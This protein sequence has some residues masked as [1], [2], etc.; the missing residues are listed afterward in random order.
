M[1]KERREWRKIGRIMVG[2][3]I[4]IM[5]IEMKGK[6]KEKLRRREIIK[7]IVDYMQSDKV[8]EYIIEE[9]MKW[10]LN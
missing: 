6:E 3:G 4:I 7:V 10:I 8:K 5:Q 1:K 9:M 2:I